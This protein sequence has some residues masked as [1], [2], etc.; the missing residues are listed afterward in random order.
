MPP[1][2]EESG[3][4][5]RP[6]PG[7]GRLRQISSLPASS[8]ALRKLLEG[9]GAEGWRENHQGGGL[10]GCGPPGTEASEWHLELSGVLGSEP[11]PSAAC[12][13]D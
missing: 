2:R 12:G 11:P 3:M 4:L 6:W 5:G 7:P 1:T 10:A 9:Q 8:A 13:Q